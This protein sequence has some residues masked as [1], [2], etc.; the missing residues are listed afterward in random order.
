VTDGPLEVCAYPG[1]PLWSAWALAR[2]A[3]R[4]WPEWQTRLTRTGN[5]DRGCGD[6]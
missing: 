1:L 4:C 3:R 6:G 5:S 2:S